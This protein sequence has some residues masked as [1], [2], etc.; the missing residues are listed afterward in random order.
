ML[1]DDDD[2]ENEYL[3]EL[4]ESRIGGETISLTECRY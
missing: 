4:A 3:I 2:M 1:D